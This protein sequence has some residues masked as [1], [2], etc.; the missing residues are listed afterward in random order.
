MVTDLTVNI[1]KGFESGVDDSKLKGFGRSGNVFSDTHFGQLLHGIR[2][3]TN[4]LLPK[5]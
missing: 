1:G 4:A 2:I 3:Q 5:H